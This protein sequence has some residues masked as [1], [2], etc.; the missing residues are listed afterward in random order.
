MYQ[1]RSGAAAGIA[2]LL[3]ELG[4]NP[5]ALIESVGL[6][7]AQFRDPDTYIPYPKLAGM[8]EL[9]ARSVG[10]PLFGLL[11][12][13]RQTSNVL[14]GLA[15]ALSGAATV[16]EA[17]ATAGKHLY[18][19]AAGIRLEQQVAGDDV[20]LTLIFDMHSKW[21]TEQLMQLSVGHLATLTADLLNIDR[22]GLPLY[23]Q[24]ARPSGVQGVTPGTRFR[25]LRFSQAFDGVVLPQQQLERA[26]RRDANLLRKHFED[27]LLELQNRYPDSVEERVR[28][29]IGH[30]L[31][32][33]EC[34]IERVAATLG[35]HPRTLQTRLG[36]QNMSYR[37]ILQQT[38][39]DLARRQLS[40]GGTS[41][42]DLALQLG[43]AEVAVFSRHFKRWSGMSPRAWRNS[44]SRSVRL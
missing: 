36:D 21:G 33:G 30:L 1:V 15:L 7:T 35:M 14:G 31:P 4:G 19:H 34:S 38:R 42:T 20:R 18:L 17:I 27:Y 37:R 39:Y 24:Q 12:A 25:R 2:K 41:V 29:I 32:A 22:F 43:Y 5:V 16:G 44:Q 40:G 28:E 9:G 6:S 3:Q 11:L 10:T 13:E 26:L 8:L 23:L